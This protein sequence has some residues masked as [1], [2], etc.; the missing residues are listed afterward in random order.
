MFNNSP[1]IQWGK[2]ATPGGN[3]TRITFPISYVSWYIPIG[4]GVLDDNNT[5]D[6]FKGMFMA[7]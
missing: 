2:S 5:N 6:I 7:T 1:K 3:A 4:V